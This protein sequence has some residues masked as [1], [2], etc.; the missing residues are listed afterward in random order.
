MTN[1]KKWGRGVERGGGSKGGGGDR[2]EGRGK[3]GKGEEE[4]GQEEMGRGDGVEKKK[5]ENRY[6]FF[7][8]LMNGVFCF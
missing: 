1:V 8:L 5:L 3:Q 2:G 7:L 4:T 6:E